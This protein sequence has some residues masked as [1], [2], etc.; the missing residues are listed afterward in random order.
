MRWSQL[1]NTI[2]PLHGEKVHLLPANPAAEALAASDPDI[3][4]LHHDSRALR[5]GNLFVA[6]R[7]LRSDGHAFLGQA[8]AKKAALAVVETPVPEQN[9]LPQF[10]TEN[11]S[12]AL[13]LLAAAF[14]GDPSA[15]LCLTGITGSNGKSTTSLMLREIY[16][17]AGRDPGL[18]GTIS[19]ESKK[20]QI[21]AKLT[22]PDAIVLQEFLA[23]VL[24]EGQEYAIMEVSSIGQE[25]LRDAALRYSVV[26]C[27]NV[28]REHID[29]HRSF[30]RYVEAKSK[31]IRQAPPHAW[32]VLNG[33]D[34]HCVEMGR[35]CPARCLYFSL[36]KKAD[37]YAEAVDLSLGQAVFDL[38]FDETLFERLRRSEIPATRTLFEKETALPLRLPVRLRVSGQHMVSDA[39]AAAAMALAAGIRPEKIVEGLSSYGGVERR[40]QEIY[41]GRHACL[42]FRVFDDHFANAGNII[43]SL[44][45]LIAMKYKKLHM[46][47]A[48][49]GLRGVT[50]TRESLE[51]LFRFLPELPLASFTAT[52]SK[53]SVDEYNEVTE[54]EFACFR[55]MMSDAKLPYTLFENLRD[56]VESIFDLAGDGDLVLLAG[57]QG[58]DAGGRL[59][60]EAAARRFP[61]IPAEDWLAPVA[62]RICGR[63]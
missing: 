46:V 27:I 12:L 31:L 50:V 53:D 3:T 56:A 13:A 32:A 28:S 1:L 35:V 15:R 55:E 38:C 8:L 37:V 14:Y 10:V 51:T 18:L 21:T 44:E 48:L 52:L 30:E 4:G 9:E 11:S 17:A 6:V 25:Q 47:Y 24:A 42:P 43:N 54:D 5:E 39:L 41:D 36:H 45:S 2:R 61:D 26:S 33:D 60:L 62:E 34:E 29:H 22:T 57:C 40:F 63:A 49:R 58:M 23:E 20:R 59:F 7:G 19:Y 16:R